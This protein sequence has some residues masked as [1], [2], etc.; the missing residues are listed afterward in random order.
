MRAGEAPR[1]MRVVTEGAVTG[2]GNGGVVTAGGVFHEISLAGAHAVFADSPDGEDGKKR[3][4]WGRGRR[5]RGASL[6]P[7]MDGGD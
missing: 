5:L 3:R 4:G 6:V 2:A 1:A 7:G